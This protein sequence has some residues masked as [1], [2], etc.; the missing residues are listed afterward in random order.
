MFKPL[1]P[2]FSNS[3]D[4]ASQRTFAISGSIFD[5]HN[6]GSGCW[7][8]ASDGSRPEMLLNIRAIHRTVSSL[9]LPPP[10]NKELSGPKCQ[11]CWGWETLLYPNDSTS[12]N[13]SLK[14]IQNTETITYMHKDT[15]W[16]IINLIFV[17][18]AKYVLL[19][20]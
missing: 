3:G 11:H 14:I 7:L 2:W 17:F 20:N 8:V 1:S 5:C 12:W 6:W 19:E 13:L 9:P 18:F 10:N 4:F 16:S 15:H